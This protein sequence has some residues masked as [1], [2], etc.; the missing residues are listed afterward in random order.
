MLKVLYGSF[1][2]A[3]QSSQIARLEREL[4]RQC[5]RIVIF[6]P[7]S[8]LFIRCSRSLVILYLLVQLR[9]ILL[10]GRSPSEVA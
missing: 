2:L 8:G 1:I 10:V 3:I 5:A 7:S 6:V 9:Y 4:V